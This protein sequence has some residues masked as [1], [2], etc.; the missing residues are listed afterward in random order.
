[1]LDQVAL[2]FVPIGVAG[3]FTGLRWLSHVRTVLSAAWTVAFKAHTQRT[4]V[5][6]HCSHG[7]DRT[8]QVDGWIGHM[9]GYV[10]SP[11]FAP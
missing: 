11:F 6:V 10:K 2:Q 9:L 7:W 3:P 1:M 8:S 5:L 4:P